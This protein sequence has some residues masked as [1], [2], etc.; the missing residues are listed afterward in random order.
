MK[1]GVHLERR[2]IVQN[3]SSAVIEKTG[4]CYIQMGENVAHESNASQIHTALAVFVP[5]PS[6]PRHAKQQCYL[7]PDY[8]RQEKTSLKFVAYALG[9]DEPHLDPCRRRVGVSL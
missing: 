9:E 2:S 7:A 1:A 5:A 3:A 8:L 6:G 4:R